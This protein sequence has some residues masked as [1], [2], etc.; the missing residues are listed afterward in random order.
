MTYSDMTPRGQ[1]RALLTSGVSMNAVDSLASQGAISDAAR[2]RYT[3][4][5]AVSTATEHPYT[6]R[7]AIDRWRSRRDAACAAISALVYGRPEPWTVYGVGA[8]AGNLWTYD[9]ATGERVRVMVYGC[10]R[11]LRGARHPG[12]TGEVD[13]RTFRTEAEAEARCAEL[14][15]TP[16]API[17]ANLRNL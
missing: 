9:D 1:L 10:E 2:R 5:W 15:A 14:N 12:P 7:W 13:P 16:R 3:R 4:L 11:Y 8:G 6:R 17:R